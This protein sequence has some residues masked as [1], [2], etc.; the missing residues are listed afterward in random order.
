[1]N[2]VGVASNTYSSYSSTKNINR[3]VNTNISSI[4]TPLTDEE[5]GLA[6]EFKDYLDYNSSLV[7]IAENGYI[8]EEDRSKIAESKS[9]QNRFNNVI[10]AMGVNFINP[11]ELPPQMGEEPSFEIPKGNATINSFEN[12]INL[13]RGGRI[14]ISGGY[15][16]I[17]DGHV[18]TFPNN[19]VFGGDLT[20]ETCY[21]D[22][23]RK[24]YSNSI[25]ALINAVES[26]NSRFTKE[27]SDN[28]LN[29][30]SNEMGIDITKDIKVNGVEFE[31][32]DGCLQTKGYVK[33]ETQTNQKGMNYLNELLQKAY[34]QNLL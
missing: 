30:L 29:L 15:I 34:E 17:A 19:M 32:V 27:V 8:S 28:V 20:E 23:T 24:G 10:S 11:Y 13:T 12:S 7:E 2:I 16:Y 26:G 9:N 6:K 18:S 25:K 1:M 31:V 14:N 3:G 4:N 5:V 22:Y 33:P 21:Y